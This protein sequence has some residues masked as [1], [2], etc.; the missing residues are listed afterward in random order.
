VKAG[1]KIVR[2]K[3]GRVVWRETSTFTLTDSYKKFYQYAKGDAKSGIWWHPEK[4]LASHNIK[5]SLIF[6]R[7]LAGIMLM[8]N[9]FKN[10]TLFSILFILLVLYIIYSFR[11][12][13][14]QTEK[15]EAGLWGIVIQFISDFSVMTGFLS[16]LLQKK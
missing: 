8:I 16:G 2:V 14:I 7:Y 12:V 15:F 3:E 1:V 11:K 5:I 13:Y 6:L 4:Q 10:P 9:S